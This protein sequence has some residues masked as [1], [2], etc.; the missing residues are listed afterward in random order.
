MTGAERR[1]AVEH[2]LLTATEDRAR[3]R[4]EWK[5]DGVALLRCG[6]VFGV[7][8]INAALVHA[9]AGT[10]APQDVDAYLLQALLGGPVFAD[11]TTLRYYV[12]VGNTT[13]LR[14]EWEQAW[15]DAECMGRGHYL[16]VPALDAT[17]P[18]RRHYWCVEMD[19]IG[20]LASVD[21]VSQLVAAGRYRLA[22]DRQP[23]G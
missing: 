17:S 6:G 11:L 3:A 13:G 5:T 19:S 21:A 2:W 9:A 20:E 16:G 1:L 15:D 14:E 18:D 22:A 4:R 23:Y 7:V 10:S 8:R 12:L